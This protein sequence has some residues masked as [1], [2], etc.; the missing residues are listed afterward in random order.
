MEVLQN[1]SEFISNLFNAT[2]FLSKYFS[3]YIQQY[4]LALTFIS[5]KY[6]C[7]PRLPAGRVQNL[8]I[9]W[10]LYYRQKNIN[11]ELHDDD[12]LYYANYTSMILYL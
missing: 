9:P 6:T 12:T 3:D 2:D 10:E 5:L 8:Q 11:A 4:N 1:I 7:D